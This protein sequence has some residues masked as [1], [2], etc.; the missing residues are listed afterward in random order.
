[1]FEGLNA[2]STTPE[3]TIINHKEGSVFI[4]QVLSEN[5]IQT[6]LLLST[7]DTIHIPNSKIKKIREHIIVYNGGK[8]HFTQGF[9]FGYSS[10]FGLSNN[11]SSSSS[12]VEFLAGYRVNEKIS[13]A[14]G[15]NSSNHFI[16]IDDFTFESVRYLPIYAHC[17]YYP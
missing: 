15:V 7:G 2:Q 17:R 4:G 13:F 12:Q 16:P 6:I 3:K 14:A 10:G 11:L 5:S 1:M 9:F 8:F